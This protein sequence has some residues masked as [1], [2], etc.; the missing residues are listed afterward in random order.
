MSVILETNLPDPLL[1]RGKVREN[2]DLGD[3]LLMVATDRISAFD[4]ILP[5][6]IPDKGMVLNLLSAFWFEK[7]AHLLPNHL[8]R[9][10][11][12]VSELNDYRP[13][14]TYP[15]FLAGRSMIVKRVKVIPVE[16]VVRGYL[17]GS[18]WAEYTQQGTIHGIPAPSGLLESQQ[19]G[20]PIF[21]PTTKEKNGHD[22][23]ISMDEMIQLVGEELAMELREKSLAIYRFAVEYA[24][25]RGIIIADTKLEFGIIDSQAILIDE[26][27]TPDSSRFW[28]AETY[29]PG[30]PQPSFDKQMV[31]DWLQSSGWNKEPP[32]PMLPSDLIE[33]TS[34]R[35][36]E[37]YQRLSGETLHKT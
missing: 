20:Q 37:V 22:Q 25:T 35:Y 3:N 18:A 31:R 27:L 23:P 13:E 8:I 11:E 34:K 32:A 33:R 36:R 7:T 9:I 21:T 26:L 29:E 6:G 10:I 2:Y 30:Q 24:R 17:S 19:L 14:Y 28:D 16:C 5:C 4:V 15:S 12:D 1:S